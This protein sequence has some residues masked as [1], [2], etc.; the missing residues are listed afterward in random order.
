[1]ATFVKDNQQFSMTKEMTDLFN[2]LKD[3]LQTISVQKDMA[4]VTFP[5]LMLII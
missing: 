2:F 3:F 4:Q 5:N 1:M